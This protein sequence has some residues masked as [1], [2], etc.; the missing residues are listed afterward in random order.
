MDAILLAAGNSVRFGKNKLLFQMNGMPLYRRML[1]L[2]YGLKKEG[3]LERV[4][5][6]SQYDAIFAAIRA[7][8]P[9]IEM[10]RNPEPELG[11]SGSIRLGILHLEQQSPKSEA[12]LFTVADQPFLT[13]DSFLKMR[14]FW[15]EHDCGIVAAAWKERIGNPVIFSANYYGELKGLEGDVGGKKVLRRHLEDTGLCQIPL[16]ELEDL[17][18][19]EAMDRIR[20]SSLDM[21]FP[22]LKEKGHVISIVG[23]GGKTTLLY[24]LAQQYARRGNRVVVTTTTHIMRPQ[25]YPVAG[26]KEE[27]YQLLQEYP[28]VVAGA[29]APGN[30]LKMADRMT[31]DDYRKAADVVLI[32]ADGAKRLPCKVPIETEPVIPKETTIVLGVMGLDAVGRPLREVCFRK[33]RAMELLGVGE[34][35]P[36]AEEDM[37]AIL[38]SDWG[39]R[40]QVGERDYY[41]VLNKCDDEVRRGQGEQIKRLLSQAGISRVICISL[42][43]YC[44][45]DPCEETERNEER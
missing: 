5:V 45:A 24:T 14:R 9:E 31:I 30:K 35:H 11:I 1:E 34:E 40:K 3:M 16:H 7:D 25:D 38:S 39:T 36:M 8:F 33:E 42:H 15:Q 13:R 43:Q 27:L 2:L 32:E 19:P 21:Y 12:C 41:V 22:F 26:C 44:K 37:A 6:V 23:A 17:D 20:Q 29:D 18:T 28:I 10:V 4:I